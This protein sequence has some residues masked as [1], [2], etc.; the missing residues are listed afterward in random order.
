MP[1]GSA[2]GLVSAPAA[3]CS[4]CSPDT[5]A[6]HAHRGRLPPR[7]LHSSP[8]TRASHPAGRLSCHA[9]LAPTAPVPGRAGSRGAGAAM[10]AIAQHAAPRP[11]EDPHVVQ[12]LLQTAEFS[13]DPEVLDGLARSE[14]TGEV[15]RKIAHI[16]DR[17]S[18]R[19]NSSHVAI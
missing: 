3:R 12:T 19:L 6:P 11:V 2:V 17:K 1:G 18:T 13:D 4:P 7:F 10:T 9:V 15:L 8:T 14:V 16:P 5:Q